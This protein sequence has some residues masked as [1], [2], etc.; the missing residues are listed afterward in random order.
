MAWK[1]LLKGFGEFYRAH[2]KEVLITHRFSLNF[3]KIGGERSIAFWT[4]TVPC[5]LLGGI[6]VQKVEEVVTALALFALGLL[7]T[8]LQA[9]GVQ[10][11]L[12]SSY[13]CRRLSRSVCLCVCVRVCTFV[14]LSVHLGLSVSM[15]VCLFVCVSVCV[16]FP[17]S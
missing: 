16:H 17:Y 5:L 1:H 7:Q 2:W 3:Y 9:C 8:M 13:R 4:S 14:C 11:S 6:E 10:E 12:Y 15:S